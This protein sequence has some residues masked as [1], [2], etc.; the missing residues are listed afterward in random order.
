MTGI[1]FNFVDKLCVV[2]V[3]LNGER[4]QDMMSMMSFVFGT[5]MVEIAH[6]RSLFS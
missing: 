3:V 5:A 1:G 2:L 6:Q 4:L